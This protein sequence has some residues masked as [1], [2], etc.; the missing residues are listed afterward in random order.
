MTD[1]IKENRLTLN[2]LLAWLGLQPQAADTALSGIATDSR[3]V[4][5]G[6]LFLA[7]PGLASDGRDYIEAAA[8]QGA[9]AILA[10]GGR[11]LPEPGIPV[12]AVDNLHTQAGD[13]LDKA[14]GHPTGEVKVIGVTGTNGKSSTVHFLGC[15]LDKLSSGCGLMGTLGQGRVGELQDMGNTTADL[16]STQRFM[17]DMRDQKVGWVAMEV[18]SHG[19]DQGRTHG[20]SFDTAVFTNLTRDHLDYHGSMEAYAEAKALLFNRPGLKYAVINLDDEWAETIRSRVPASVQCLAV[21]LENPSADMYLENI[22]LHPQGMAADIVSPWGKGHLE[23]GLLGRFNLSNLLGVIGVMGLQGFALDDVLKAV[24]S[25]TSVP[26]RMECFGGGDQPTVA[27]DYA[28]TSDALK[29]VLSALR[30][31]GGKNVICVFGCGGDRDRGKRLLMAQAACAGADKVV[32]TTDNPRSENPE[33]IIDDALSGLN[34]HQL[35]KVTVVVDR[36]QAIRQAITD[37]SAGDVVLIAGKGHETYQEIM[38][39][40]YPF[41]DVEEV[42]NVLSGVTL[43]GGEA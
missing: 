17:A 27:V 43:A 33:A 42:R 38:G 14:F 26:G 18:S 10:E 15:L 35:E 4:R 9:A 30:E 31:H 32:I 11:E 22:Q 41:S 6:D 16:L 20:I 36:A 40:R 28:H 12:V 5:S 37:A 1:F 25:L 8:A 23:S 29:S 24:P 39:V 34:G 21:S 13:L 19:L 7:L 3:R 2:R